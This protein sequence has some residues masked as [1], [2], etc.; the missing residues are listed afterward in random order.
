MAAD[1]VTPDFQRLLDILGPDPT[2]NLTVGQ[3]L[4]QALFFG[5]LPNEDGSYTMPDHPN[6]HKGNLKMS[7]WRNSV[8]YY[9]SS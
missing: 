9:K 8:R 5:I 7:T 4:E 1:Y 2:E 3:K 6:I